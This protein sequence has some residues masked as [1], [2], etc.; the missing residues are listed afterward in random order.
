MTIPKE[1]PIT[2]MMGTE[3]TKITY[4]A[5]YNSGMSTHKLSVDDLPIELVSGNHWLNWKDFDGRKSPVGAQGYRKGYNDPSTWVPLD[6]AINRARCDNKLHVGL[7]L[8]QDGLQI[9]DGWL[10]CLDFDGFVNGND[11]DDAVHEYLDAL[12]TYVEISPSKTGLKAFFTTDKA[13]VDKS[14]VKFG[15]SRFAAQHPSV[16]K[17]KNREIEIF[18]CK[19]FLTTTGD[20]FADKTRP[21]RHIPEAEV[22]NLLN[23][24]H[25]WAVNTGGTGRDSNLKVPNRPPACFSTTYTK[26][27]IDQLDLALLHIEAETE[28]TWSDVVNILARVYGED[29]R[30]SWHVYSLKSVKY[31]FEKCEERYNRALRELQ[32]RPDG[33]GTKHLIKLASE[34]PDWH[35]VSQQFEYWGEIPASGSLWE[36][37]PIQLELPIKDELVDSVNKDY[38]WDAHGLQIYSLKTRMY[39]RKD[40]FMDHYQNQ[41][42]QVASNR[43]VSLGRYWMESPQRRS[44]NG[45]ALSPSEGEITSTGAFNTWR[46]YSCDPVQGDISPFTDVFNHLLPDENDRDYVLKWLARLIQNPETPFKVALAI[47][48]RTQGTGKNTIFEAIG[49]LFH[50]Q[51]WGVIGNAQMVGQFN[52]W[53]LDKVFIIGDEVSNA[54]S[55]SEADL[56]KRYITATENNINPKGH[57]AMRQLNLIKYV[58]LSNRDEIVHIEGEDRRYY[59]AET[60]GTRLPKSIADRFYAWK[61]AGGLSHL[62]F[63]LLNFDASD[64]DPTA[65]APMT[66]AKAG[67]IE[68][69]KSGLELWVEEEV[70]ELIAQGKLLAST[71]NLLSC[72]QNSTR[73]C[74]SDKAM[75]NALQR[76][77][78]IKLPKQAVLVSGRRIRLYSLGEHERFKVMPDSEL[79]KQFKDMYLQGG[80]TRN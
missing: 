32:S 46:G 34:N 39:V 66:D 64:F 27:S 49:E 44:V 51:H 29:A 77:G 4:T 18:S 54:S 6:N 26:L 10:W 65:P 31:N 15:P 25:K 19:S 5:N 24:L 43:S 30:E 14:K 55:R 2:A 52:D 36:A 62:L 45:L 63:H 76:A 22:D 17:Y 42:V 48:G 12:A 38:L 71:G 13:P 56:M 35:K 74:T 75:S 9:G 33:Y 8:K 16:S 70:S 47:H 59:V 1:M 78:G 79:G 69:G 28:N 61:H 60:T 37:N 72:Y 11:A 57:P 58:L 40:G 73:N 68:A 50:S 20:R 3:Q 41:K 23:K 67:V 53:Q 7:T 80:V 21:L